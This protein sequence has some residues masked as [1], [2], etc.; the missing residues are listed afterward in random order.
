[1][2]KASPLKHREK[3]SAHEFMSET[4]HDAAHDKEENLTNRFRFEDDFEHI[5][6]DDFEV[7]KR[8]NYGVPGKHAGYVD[9]EGTLVKK[10]TEKYESK[11]FKFE[12][13]RIGK[14]AIKVTSPDGTP[15]TITLNSTWS[16][17]DANPQAHQQLMTVLNSNV[18]PEKKKVFDKTGLNPNDDGGYD[19]DL[20]VN[21]DAGDEFASYGGLAKRKKSI[22]TDEAL[23]IAADIEGELTK[24]LT[25]V[26]EDG[27]RYLG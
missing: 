22:K 12:E 9:V 11:G 8:E 5:N 4:M 20:Q 15:T 13:A 21:E 2:L 24:A 3:G 25:S 19:I 7:G 14:D 23:D 27:Q 18:D 16:G 1:M 6:K 26:G 10:L 17:F